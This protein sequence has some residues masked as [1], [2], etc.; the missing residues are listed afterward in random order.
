MTAVMDDRPQS[1][2]EAGALLGAAITICGVGTTTENAP[3]KGMHSSFATAGALPSSELLM[4]LCYLR[5][6]LRAAPQDEPLVA[7]PS[8]LAVLMKLLGTSNELAAKNTAANTAAGDQRPDVPPM[9]STPLRKLWVDCVVL[10]HRLGEGLSGTARTSLFSFLKNMIALAGM[11]PR[12]A[13]ETGGARI[14]A[15]DVIAGLLE[16]E[17]L[18]PKIAGWAHDILQLCLRALRSSGN[19][20]PTYRI[21]AVRMACAVAKATRVSQLKSKPVEIPSQT[22]LLP[23]ALETPAVLEAVK[24]LKQAA[25]DK[26]PEVRSAAA[27]FAAI[28]S[29]L[30][31]IL[32][33]SRPGGK[34]E[35]NAATVHLD[36]VT[37]LCLRNLDDEK[38]DVAA[39][40]SEAL[41][42]CI[43]TAIEVGQ[44]KA[45][46]AIA[47]RDV[48]ADQD[49]PPAST[50]TPSPRGSRK[51]DGPVAICKDLK[52]GI[53]FLLKNFVKVGGESMAARAGGTYS[54]GGR[55]VRV[56]LANSLT[57]LLRIQLTLGVIGH[58]DGL[59]LQETVLLV[60]KMAGVEAEKQFLLPPSTQTLD[61]TT[62]ATAETNSPG[63]NAIFGAKRSVADAGL[64]RQSAGSVIRFGI[65]E[66]AT[67]TAQLSLLQD[68][69]QLLDPTAASSLGIDCTANQIQVILVEISHLLCALGEASASKVEILSERLKAC[70]SHPSHGV[71]HEAAVACGAF[72]ACHPAEGRKML[73]TALEDVQTR[74]AELMVVAK[75]GG[76]EE[77]GG[78]STDP[79][80]SFGRM[81]RRPKKEAE[82]KIDDPT[83]THQYAIHG[84]CLMVSI[85]VRELPHVSGGIAKEHIAAALSLAEVL[86]A[87]QFNEVVAKANPSVA[88]TCVRAG[89][90]IIA[91]LLATGPAAIET[92]IKKILDLL[93]NSYKYSIKGGSC[94]SVDHDLSCAELVLSSIVAFLSYCS[95]L[96]LSVPEVLSEISVILEELLSSFKENGRFAKESSNPAAIVRLKTAKACLLE[97]FA[98][99]PS[100][101]F[102]IAADNVF[103]FA[104]E[105]I[106]TAIAGE[107]S[108]SILPSLVTKEDLLLDAKSM[109]RVDRAGQVGGAR[110]IE[111]IMVTLTSEAALHG[112]RE[113]VLHFP[114]SH[115][116]HVDERE[117]WH[118]E[119]LG[120]FAVDF[121]QPPPT[122]LHAAVGTWRKP[123]DVSC[124]STVRLIDASVQAFAATF[125][126]KGGMEQQQ[127]MEMLES[128]VP[129]FLT[130][131]ATSIGMTTALTEQVSRVKP[132]ED[133]AAVANITAVLLSCLKALPLHE[134]THNV[135]I[136]LGPPWMNKAKDL[137][138]TLLPSASNIVR[139]SAAEGLA[140]LATLGVSEDAH[141]LQSAVL[142]SLDEVMRGNQPD[143]K[144]KT[145]PFEPISASRAG[146]LLALACIQRMAHRVSVNRK[147]RTRGRA[148]STE[149][150]ILQEEEKL[151]TVQMMTRILPS[152]GRQGFRDF[153]IVQTHALHAFGLL[154]GYSLKLEKDKLDA[155]DLQLLR[156]GVELIEDNFIASWTAASA[157]F[158]V[159]Q[160]VSSTVWHTCL[161]EIHAGNS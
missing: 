51:K 81:F 79:K 14:A 20:E 9:L 100:G 107:V 59:S 76:N 143:G 75:R 95:E 110:D 15:L 53:L 112:E 10:C 153:F 142:H 39:G 19:G 121:Y 54:I 123:L 86:V 122:Q 34:E 33:K 125:G 104:A 43:C 8:L 126:L 17:S 113:S 55:A 116:S 26:F 46:S 137:L 151:P 135:P 130:Q 141:F 127:A 154:L 70:L 88:C 89:F 131:L 42:R 145:L 140:L 48:E 21:S 72:V 93:Q 118:S 11:N 38:A 114:G 45:S 115:I 139:R 60:L 117:F 144:P 66:L 5:S 102:P 80:R 67:E 160:E 24:V 3:P 71:R 1:V 91:G 6:L 84:T 58:E 128:L 77:A 74:H 158:D 16:D 18:A 92:H 4:R 146:S 49:D 124:S 29:S 150:V 23:G 68:L 69:L 63:S 120:L 108:C 30:L 31:V 7:A 22:M 98:W 129:P 159:G 82:K 109:P 57:K 12:S 134:A 152:V 85:A 99:L 133:S 103:A 27:T 132:K 28:V 61:I 56:G 106:R 87:C 149:E 136:G 40:W 101:S 78:I 90:G 96:L 148:L 119:I 161:D 155:E 52:S 41:A 62:Q 105:E 111:D 138:L 147:D 50:A 73:V 44:R 13:K 94:L 97:A 64:V 32:P 37:F 156:K 157:D 36:D 2:E 83:L 47:K 35:P 65:S 25:T